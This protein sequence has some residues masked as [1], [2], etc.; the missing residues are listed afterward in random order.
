[1]QNLQ[2][3][4]R[5][6]QWLMMYVWIM[7]SILHGYTCDRSVVRPSACPSASL[8]HILNCTIWKIEWS[9]IQKFYRFR[10]TY[11]DHIQ[12]ET[13]CD[14]KM[15]KRHLRYSPKSD[16]FSLYDKSYGWVYGWEGGILIF[17]GGKIK[18]DHIR[19]DAEMEC[20]IWSSVA[21]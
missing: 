14:K 4:T 17:P 3:P 6:Q 11:S 1:M 5:K 19:L 13:R 10:S 21:D 2:E 8:H 15:V 20:N 7:I 9:S 12:D 18:I 16:A